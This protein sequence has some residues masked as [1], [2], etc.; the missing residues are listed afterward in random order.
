MGIRLKKVNRL[1]MANFTSKHAQ[2]GVSLIESMISVLLMA[3]LGL[4]TAYATSQILVTQRFAATQSLAVIQMREYLQTHEQPEV[5]VAG[6]VLP[7]DD[8]PQSSE[9]AIEIGGKSRPV[10]LTH[11]RSMSV[12]STDLFSGDG[13]ISL[14]Y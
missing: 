3:V 9:I 11:S 13:S 8:S 7:I 5:N 1:K 14:T 2:Q 12:S 10:T 4:G 6:Y